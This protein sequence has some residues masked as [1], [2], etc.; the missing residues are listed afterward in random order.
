MNGVKDDQMKKYELKSGI[1]PKT[2]TWNSEEYHATTAKEWQ[3]IA[4]IMDR[5]FLGVWAISNL[6]ALITTLVL[7]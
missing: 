5:I 4:L 1:K 6:A 2:E 7:L 3:I